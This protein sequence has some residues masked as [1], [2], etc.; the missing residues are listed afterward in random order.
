MVLLFLAMPAVQA[1]HSHPRANEKTLAFG[2]KLVIEKFVEHCKLCEFLSHQMGKDMHLSQPIELVFPIIQ[3]V[4]LT[5][6][7]ISGNH[8][9]TL[10]GFTNK[11]PPI[12]AFC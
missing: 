4:K 2:E 5:V 1:V 3:P 8:T 12:L 10:Q 7:L 6:N 9:F 11:G